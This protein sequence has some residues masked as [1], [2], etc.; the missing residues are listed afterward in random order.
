M[1]VWGC[2]MTKTTMIDSPGV[3][4]VPI[5]TLQVANMIYYFKDGGEYPQWW[6]GIGPGSN[7]PRAADGTVLKVN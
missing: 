7:S 3:P 1:H 5:D 6:N 2:L 4:V